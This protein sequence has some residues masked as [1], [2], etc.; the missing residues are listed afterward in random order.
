MCERRGREGVRGNQRKEKRG[1][2]SK[3]SEATEASGT[4]K[5]RR[6][7]ERESVCANRDLLT[8]SRKRKKGKEEE[9]ENKEEI[10]YYECLNEQTKKELKQEAKRENP[11]TKLR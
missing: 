1:E 8:S 10:M 3:R 2:G 4:K 7:E 5:G 9:N 6:K 11:P